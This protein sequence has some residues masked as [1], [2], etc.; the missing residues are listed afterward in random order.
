[1]DKT[2][3]KTIDEAFDEELHYI[4]GRYKGDITSVRTP[5]KKLNDVY[6]DGFEWGWIITIGG[7]S[8]VGKTA[9]LNDLET[10]FFEENPNDFAVLNFNF[11]MQARRL[12]GRKISRNMN[13]TVKDVY[14]VGSKLSIPN[15]NHIKTLKNNL[16]KYDVTYVEKSLSINQIEEA[17][18]TFFKNHKLKTNKEKFI[19]TLDHTLLVK[20]PMNLDERIMLTK[21]IAKF[22]DMKKDH[23][24]IFILLSQLNRGLE[25]SERITN[26]KLHYPMKSDLFGSDAIYQGSDAV[27]LVHRPEILGITKYGP[28]GL[29]TKDIVYVHNIKTR[30]GVP[31]ICT[32]GNDLKFNKL[33]EINVSTSNSNSG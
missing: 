22:N 32:F 24:V 16:A 10:G 18:Y 21:L 7:M 27:M 2:L 28:Q 12:M 20:N 23:Q 4:E 9:F 11:E 13:L 14:S 3:F 5:Y 1:M 25:S 15:L 8:G 6:M 19:V 31:K 26:S 17:C 30:D 29:P 33:K